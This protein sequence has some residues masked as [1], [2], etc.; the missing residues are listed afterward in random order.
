MNVADTTGDIFSQTHPAFSGFPISSQFLIADFDHPTAA[1]ESSVGSTA[2]LDLEY[3]GAAG[4][5]GGSW[6]AG[7]EAQT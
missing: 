6:Y 1:S 2:P 3:G 7:P 4:D 5:S